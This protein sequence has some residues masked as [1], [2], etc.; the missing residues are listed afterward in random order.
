MMNNKVQSQ[1][2]VFV[3]WRQLIPDNNSATLTQV[4]Y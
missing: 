3:L 4:N 1:M 2:S